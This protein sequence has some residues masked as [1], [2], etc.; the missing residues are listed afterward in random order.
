MILEPSKTTLAY[1]CPSCGG[2]PTSVVGIFSLSGQLFKLKCDCGGSHMTVEKTSDDKLRL[3]VPCVACPHPHSYLLSKNVFFE[4]ES[5]IIGCSTC[6][7][8]ICFLG[9]D[10]K[11]K[12]AIEYSNKELATMLGD[13]SLEK[14]KGNKSSQAPFDPQIMDIV[15]FV[16]N[17]LNEEGKIYCNCKEN[18][19]DYVV[20]ILEDFV[21]VK[22]KKCGAGAIIPTDSTIAAYDFLNTDSITLK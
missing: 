1:R 12:E 13:Y 5:F 22:C 8:D 2:V 18:E 6:G 17:D 11:V 21:S 10:E 20:D 15:R 4:S 19:G 14:L 16:I 3:T 7:V 9:T